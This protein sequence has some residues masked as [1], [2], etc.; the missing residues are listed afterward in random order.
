MEELRAVITGKLLWVAPTLLLSWAGFGKLSPPMF[1]SQWPSIASARI[2]SFPLVAAGEVELQQKL[3]AAGHFLPLPK[4]PAA[5]ANVIEVA[6]ADFLIRA[7]KSVPD[8][9]IFRGTERGY[10]DLEIDGL[11]FGGVQHAVD[12]KVARRAKSGKQTDSRQHVRRAH[13]VRL[14]EFPLGS[15]RSHR[16][17]FPLLG[18]TAVSLRGR[19]EITRGPARES[20]DYPRHQRRA[21]LVR[22]PEGHNR[23]RNRTLSRE[24]CLHRK[25]HVM[26]A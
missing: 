2:P 19:L 16:D 9:T 12:I 1:L 24:A 22:A 25:A 14:Q 5:L 13:A 8:A 26:D 20:A 4:E 11:P 18:R 7:I 23:A 17:A 15:E 21:R 3:T 6:V 10:P